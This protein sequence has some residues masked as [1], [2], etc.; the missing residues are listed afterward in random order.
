[1]K[2]DQ[3]YSTLKAASLI[4]M[5]ARRPGLTPLLSG[6]AG[7]GKTQIVE[8]VAKE[9]N[10]VIR[11]LDGSILNEGEATGLP[12]TSK[13][14]SGELN[15]EF[16]KHADI[17]A[18]K[19]L[20][21]YYYTKGQEEGFM[22]GK[23][24]LLEDGTFVKD[25]KEYKKDFA[26]IITDGVDNKYAWGESDEELTPTEKLELIKSGEIHPF[27]L[28]IDEINRCDMQT[29]K[30]LMNII[31]ERR[32][33]GY[34]FP[35]WVIVI[36][37]MNP[38]GQDSEYAT[39]QFDP[40]QRDRFCKI[41]VST[42][43]EL[44]A[45]YCLN[46]GVYQPAIE[47]LINSEDIFMVKKN[48][49]EDNTDDMQP[50]PRSWEIVA[51]IAYWLPK[52]LD[53]SEYFTPEEKGQYNQILRALVVG[54][55]G[56]TAGTTWIGNMKNS[57][58]NTPADKIFTG[59]SEHLDPS[60]AEKIRKQ[61]ALRKRFTANSSINF[62]CEHFTDFEKKGKDDPKILANFTSQIKEFLSLID[63]NP[64]LFFFKTIAGNLQKYSCKDKTPLF[65]KVSR[66]ASTEI[67]AELNA[68]F[69]SKKDANNME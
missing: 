29:M 42:D 66:F 12:I 60:I 47:A 6:Q 50:S 45:T 16:A 36:A 54:K 40:A 37:A 10:A 28:F 3:V 48:S 53:V 46:K 63:K 67:L 51:N 31:L 18:I 33:N 68:F 27:V 49:Y 8:Q 35:W 19:E 22:N 57:E 4:Q 2:L 55:V 25:G 32:V 44:F 21:K 23:I 65:R 62:L 15:V 59:K 58:L 38:A 5:L 13:S 69:N 56:T 9:L 41:P 14:I 26:S 17:Q 43:V 24:K 20:Q 39:L 11:V 30:Q 64:R 52:V 34:K 1:M 7:V 61:S